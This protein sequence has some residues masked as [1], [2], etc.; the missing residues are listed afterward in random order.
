MRKQDDM[1]LKTILQRLT[2]GNEK[3]QGEKAQ[4]LSLL[5]TY[6]QSIEGS[7]HLVKVNVTQFLQTSSV[8]YL[9]EK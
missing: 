4:I 8:Y 9:L 1:P 2:D 7:E 6:A 5:N 3:F